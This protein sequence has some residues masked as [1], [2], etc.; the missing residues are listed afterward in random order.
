MSKKVMHEFSQWF[1]GLWL[2]YLD[3]IRNLPGM[4]V[5]LEEARDITNGF[6]V[7]EGGEK[8]ARQAES[9]LEA[10]TRALVMLLFAMHFEPGSPTK[11]EVLWMATEIKERLGSVRRPRGEMKM[12]GT[13]AIAEL[14]V[15]QAMKKG[16]F[17]NS[18]EK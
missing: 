6:I 2:S 1:P 11:G 3:L 9:F 4:C 17:G 14:S 5:Q 12:A 7:T 15:F 16:E 8:L 18:K 13:E 10:L